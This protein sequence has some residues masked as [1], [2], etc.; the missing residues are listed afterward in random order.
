[1]DEDD[2]TLLGR[3]QDGDGESFG[4]L[5]DRTR[6]W[7]LSC[8]IL[9]RVGPADAEDVLSETYRTA[10]E[11]VSGFEWRGA[12][13]LHW[14]AAI[15]KRKAL[16]RV[17]KRSSLERA[18][19]DIPSLL[20]V[21]DDVPTAEADVIAREALAGLR[22][23]VAETLTRIPPRYAEALRLRLLEGRP[24]EACADALAVTP[25]TFDVVLHRATRAFARKWREA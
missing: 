16:E 21:P 10:L 7:L 12:G 2:R 4:V 6:G 11:K 17:R 19:E 1:M 3:I 13:L 8:V 15:A 24:R 9:P 23:R 18:L 20:D 5:Y 22:S 14:L 25:S